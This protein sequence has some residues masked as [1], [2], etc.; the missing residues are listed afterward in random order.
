MP[1]WLLNFPEDY[2]IHL[3]R[4]LPPLLR[5][6]LPDLRLYALPIASKPGSCPVSVRTVSRFVSLARAATSQE[7]QMLENLQETILVLLRLQYRIRVSGQI[8]LCLGHPRIEQRGD[9]K[10]LCVWKCTYVLG[11]HARRQKIG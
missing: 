4:R 7:N 9:A 8:F 3:N 1:R 6:L 10:D 5:T 2:L 11:V